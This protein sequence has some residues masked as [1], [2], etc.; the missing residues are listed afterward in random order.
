[1]ARIESVKPRAYYRNYSNPESQGTLIKQTHNWPNGEVDY[2]TCIYQFDFVQNPSRKPKQID[3]KVPDG[4]ECGSSYVDRMQDWDSAKW[5]AF[6][7]RLSGDRQ[8]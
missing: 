8:V 2:G 7:A 4:L 3:A 1:M 6:V 5:K